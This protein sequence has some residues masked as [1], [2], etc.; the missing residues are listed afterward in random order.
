M[1]ESFSPLYPDF[2][3]SHEHLKPFL[4]PGSQGCEEGSE[5]TVQRGGGIRG[6]GY[7]CSGEEAEEVVRHWGVGEVKGKGMEQDL[8]WI[9]ARKVRKLN[10]FI[11]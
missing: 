4:W 10:N 1:T 3:P 5:L 6:Q 7:T 8:L 2:M 9:S 11:K